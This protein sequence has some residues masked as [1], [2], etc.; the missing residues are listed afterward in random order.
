M[1][2]NQNV[3]N[4]YNNNYCEVFQCLNFPIRVFS[5]KKVMFCVSSRIL[6]KLLNVTLRILMVFLTIEMCEM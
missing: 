4:D 6:A 2:N 5:H 1:F 3:K